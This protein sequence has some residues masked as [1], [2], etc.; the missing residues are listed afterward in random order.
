MQG[1]GGCKPEPLALCFG[2][3]RSLWPNLLA[4]S[5]TRTASQRAGVICRSSLLHGTK[6]V[7]PASRGPISTVGSPPIAG[8]ADVR[9]DSALPLSFMRN[10]GNVAFWSFPSLA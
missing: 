10:K 5:R 2:R 6:L 4:N 7:F 8:M 3:S 1:V 9:I